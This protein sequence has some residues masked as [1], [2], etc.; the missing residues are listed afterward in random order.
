MVAQRG[1]I[2]PRAAV[3][4]GPDGL[5]HEPVEDRGVE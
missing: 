4:P 5:K 1:V 2:L 3:A